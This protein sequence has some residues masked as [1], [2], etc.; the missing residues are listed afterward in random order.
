MRFFRQK[1]SQNRHILGYRNKI[2]FMCYKMLHNIDTVLFQKLLRFLS[3]PNIARHSFYS[4][5]MKNIM[6]RWFFGFFYFCDWL[7]QNRKKITFFKTFFRKS[8]LDILFLS[9]FQNPKKL[10]K[11][12][13]YWKNYQNESGWFF[14]KHRNKILKQYI[15]LFFSH[16]YVHQIPIQSIS[17]SF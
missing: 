10:L 12:K 4:N 8:I 3:L 16:K 15:L 14:M 2:F 7:S 9:K 5:F 6:V 11:K 17:Q 13:C 1:H